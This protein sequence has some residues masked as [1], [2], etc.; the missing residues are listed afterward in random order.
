MLKK[1][2][3]SIGSFGLKLTKQPGIRAALADTYTLS[4]CCII[5][6]ENDYLEEWINYHLKTGVEHFY[7]YDNSSK[8]PVYDTLKKLNLLQYATV[9]RIRGKAKQVR[10]YNKC[11]KKY[12]K[13]SQWIGFIDTDE[14]MVPKTT[15]GNL[16]EFL[17]DYQ[18][19]G[20][21]G[22]NWLVFGS[23]GHIKKTNR[24]QLESFTLRSDETFSVN[25]HIKNI[26]QPR[27]TKEALGAHSFAYKD[28]KF[29]VNE[30][31]VRIDGSFSEVSVNKIQLNHY[32]CRSKEEYDA[33][34]K[35]G[36]G[37]TSKKRKVDEFYYHDKDANKVE[38]TTI[39]QLFQGQ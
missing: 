8:V 39:L 20:G 19:Y 9:T 37:D 17:K 10:A 33:K 25:S 21:L 11:L 27:F 28:G 22:I 30:N 13:T 31:F 29:C 5:K 2:F 6:D 7:I 32:Y 35:R 36:Y 1:L 18:D 15:S 4:L 12:G 26:V 14:F 3:S 24:P 34:V 16:V 38:D 23:N